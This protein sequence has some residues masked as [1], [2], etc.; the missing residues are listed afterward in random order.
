MADRERGVGLMP[1][2]LDA[3][4]VG[5]EASMAKTPWSSRNPEYRIQV[6]SLSPYH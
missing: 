4:L 6:F 2:V 3:A 1:E 5:Q